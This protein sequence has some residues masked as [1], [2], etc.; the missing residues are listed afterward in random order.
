MTSVVC[1]PFYCGMLAFW[2]LRF[3]PA[4][5]PFVKHARTG[6]LGDGVSGMALYALHCGTQFGGG[7]SMS[8]GK[9]DGTVQ[10]VL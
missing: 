2:R 7:P 3:V 10:A 6:I 8:A 4:V 1:G 5:A 9:I